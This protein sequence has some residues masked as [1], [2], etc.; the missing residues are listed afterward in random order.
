MDGGDPHRAH[1]VPLPPVGVDAVGHEGPLLPEAELGVGLPILP[2][3]RVQTTHQLHLRPVFREVGLHRQ[4]PLPGQL[5]QECHQSVR[6]GG[7]EAGRQ[8]GLEAPEVLTFLQPAE[9]LPDGL[10]RGL[11]QAL[12]AVAVHVHLADIAPDPG[13]LQLLHEDEGGRAV[14]GGEDGDPGGAV[15]HEVVGQ[16]PVEFPGVALVGAAGLRGEGIGLQ[17]VQQGQVHA[18]GHHGVLGGVEV[19][20]REGLQNQGVPPVLH[21][22]GGIRLRQC[23][24]DPDD[25]SVLRREI[26]MLRDGQLPQ[27][28]GGDDVAFQNRQCHEKFLLRVGIWRQKRA[29]VR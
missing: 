13:S 21:W 8:D 23:R 10:L 25:L 16:A 22:R 12:P 6:A 1:G 20:V 18:H 3:V 19:Q 7:G 17:P 11:L 9:G 27:G 26:A 28:G 24:E 15:F 5:P 14:E 4:V 2:A 29:P